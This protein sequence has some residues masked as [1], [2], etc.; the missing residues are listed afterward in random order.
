MAAGIL[1]F[2]VIDVET[3]N[4]DSASVCQVGIAVVKSGEIVETWSQLVNP[5][6]DCWTNTRTHGITAFMARGKPTFKDIYPRIKGSFALG[7]VVSHSWFDKGAILKACARYGLPTPQNEWRDSIAIAKRAWPRRQKG[8]SLP[9][10]AE[11]LG[12]RYKSHDAGED[13]RATATLVLRAGEILGANRMN[14]WL[15]GLAGASGKRSTS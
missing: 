9:T 1:N 8:Y 13:A 10:I 11:D 7:R 6:T 2:T 14:N 3:A 4:Y 15:I 5:Q 12:I